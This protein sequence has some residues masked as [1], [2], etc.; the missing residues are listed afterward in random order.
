MSDDEIDCLANSVPHPWEWLV[1]ELRRVI[2]SNR[3]LL[4]GGLPAFIVGTAVSLVVLHLLRTKKSEH[5]APYF[6]QA[7]RATERG[8][9]DLALLCAERLMQEKE[10][11]P[12]PR[13]HY[14]MILEAK[15]DTVGSR[16]IL[17]QLAP[18]DQVGFPPAHL[19][20]A[21]SFMVAG[22]N[23]QTMRAVEWHLQ[24]ALNEATIADEARLLLGQIYTA[25]GQSQRAEPHLRAAA[26][27][28]PAL[29]LVLARMAR[30]RGDRVGVDVELDSAVR[31]FSTRVDANIDDIDARLLW[32]RA[33]S[34]R[35]D[36]ASAVEIIQNGLVR[37]DDPRYH[38]ALARIYAS[39]VRS[40]ASEDPSAVGERLALLERGLR[41]DTNNQ[42]LLYDLAKIIELRGADVGRIRS[43]LQ[44]WIVDGKATAAIHFVL[45]LDAFSRG[46]GDEAK[47]HWEQAFRLEPN[48]A[49]VANN[50]AWML[51]HGDCPDLTRALELANRAVEHRPKQPRFRGT[52][53]FVLLKLKHWPE[54]LTDLEASLAADP[55]SVQ[56]HQ[57]LAEV[58][59]RLGS[60]ELSSQH[61]KRALALGQSAV[62]DR[63]PNDATD[64]GLARLNQE[65]SHGTTDS[66][67]EE[68]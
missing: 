31:V 37:S 34:T 66:G 41:H 25:T 23:P 10:S 52:R 60:S 42:A 62:R 3:R 57:D 32:A 27:R 16:S 19:A 44:A 21:R 22:L 50:L 55:N 38:E 58:Y 59:E 8:Q 15:G 28:F 1:G 7:A 64:T 68:K 51:A 53:A 49:M 6:E 30:E 9:F 17:S 13:Y 5:L 20:L 18:I 63:A 43:L 61:R 29:R 2:I 45:G 39:W 48:A 26:D 40:R 33:V 46:K 14:A 47:L 35:A 12:G 54:A 56:T 11:E 65:H 36:F 67:I 4:F 24:H